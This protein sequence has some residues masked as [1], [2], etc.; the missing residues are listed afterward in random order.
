MQSF[1]VIHAEILSARTRV[2]DELSDIIN[3]LD[4]QDY[5][6]EFIELR[7]SRCFAVG[8]VED[9]PPGDHCTDRRY[10]PSVRFGVKH[11]VRTLQRDWVAINVVDSVKR[12]TNVSRSMFLTPH[13]LNTI[14]LARLHQSHRD[15]IFNIW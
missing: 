14:T 9:P 6:A 2:G 5:I 1:P 11:C 15:E 7:Q 13:A 8:H 12:I 10:D 4:R 3:M